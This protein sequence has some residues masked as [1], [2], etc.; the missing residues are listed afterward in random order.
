MN[1]KALALS[2]ILPLCLAGSALAHE[3]KLEGTEWGYVGDQEPAARFI[4]FAGEQ[5]VFGYGGCNRFSG[6]FLQ[7]GLQLMIK[8]LATTKMACPPENMKREDEFL[9]LL[10][11]VRGIRVEQ[12]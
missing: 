10:G 9:A 7:S 11:K 4:S 12:H 5:R 2:A 8:P 6:E 3:M 1:C